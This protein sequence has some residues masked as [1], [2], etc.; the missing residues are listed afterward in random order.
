ML[1][2]SSS[3]RT[4]GVA[5]SPSGGEKNVMRKTTCQFSTGISTSQHR[6]KKKKKSCSEKRGATTEARS[7]SFVVARAT[8]NDE[9]N[10]CSS[11][12]KDR[13]KTRNE[14]KKY[15]VLSSHSRKKDK[16]NNLVAHAFDATMDEN[17]D[18]NNSEINKEIKIVKPRF[19][20]A[21]DPEVLPR[22]DETDK[23]IMKLFI[24]AVLNFLIIPLVGIVDVFWV[25]RMGDAVALAAQGAANQV[26]QSAFWI[27]SFIPS[28]VA[29]MVARAAAGGDKAELQNKI[30]EGIFCAFIVGLFGMTVMG[31]LRNPALGLVGLD[32]VSATGIQAAPYIGIRALTFIPAIVSTVGFAAFRGTLD[33]TTPMKITLAS[34]LMNVILDPIFIFGFG[35]IKA[36][37]VA[38]AALATSMSELV[39]AGLYIGTL[40]K[41]NLVTVRSMLKPPDAKAIGALLVGGAGVQLRSLAQN[42]TFLAVTRT[43]LTMDS[44]G[45]AAA[46]HTVS[47]Q[48]FQLGAIAI[49]ALSTIATILIPQRMHSKELGGPLA[50]KAVADRLLAW[51]IL[52][53]VLLFFMQS[54]A[55]FALPFFTPIKDVQTFAVLPTLIGAAL[56][57]LNGIVFVAEGLMQGHQA[58]LRLA[59]GMFVSTGVMLTALRFEGSTLPGVWM[60]FAAFNTCRLLFALRHHFVDGPL[61]WKHLNANQMKWEETN[62]SA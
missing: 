5:S 3:S 49:L 40:L 4:G 59:G 42:I 46:A 28:V 34:Q 44:T 60:C 45:T 12:T 61:G 31:C 9:R 36:L 57:P 2:S 17:K 13:R 54:A 1:S 51:G 37:G 19:G 23:L 21:I 38:G 22:N 10:G 15:T 32:P 26:F 47:S 8:T 30:G 41:R 14:N 29:P 33:V 50:A 35:T 52:I 25:G 16:N 18:N 11:F 27:I 55:I 43:I 58:F 62:K 56:Q 20:M 6:A 53:G 24:P 48:V 39:A 7:S